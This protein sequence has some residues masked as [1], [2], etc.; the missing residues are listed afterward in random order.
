[1]QPLERAAD[2]TVEGLA[3]SRAASSGADHTL[4][5]R[6]Q[7]VLEGVGHILEGVGHILEGVGHIL[8]GVGHILAVA[9]RSLAA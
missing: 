3:H 2:R 1:M 7:V 5:E 8:E 6:S 9:G 4:V